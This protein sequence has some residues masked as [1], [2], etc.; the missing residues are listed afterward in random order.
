MFGYFESL[1]SA[2]LPKIASEKLRIQSF[3]DTLVA[4]GY[5]F[6]TVEFFIDETLDLFDSLRD[7]IQSGQASETFLLDVFNQEDRSNAILF[8]FRVCSLL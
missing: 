1:M 7:G 2:G 6:A 8:H 4:V 5:D 3:N